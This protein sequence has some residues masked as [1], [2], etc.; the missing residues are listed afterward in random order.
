MLLGLA[1]AVAVFGIATAVQASIPDANGVIH[2]CY[3]T[4]VAHG[5]PTGAL[6]VID[7]AK[8]NGNCT[9]WEA[10]LN[11]LQSTPTG[12]TGSTGPTGPPGPTGP[13]GPTGPVN[14]IERQGLVLADGTLNFS[15]GF[16]V[17]HTAGSGNYKINFPAGTF[18]AS[19]STTDYPAIVA[20]PVAGSLLLRDIGA[21]MHL[22]GSFDVTLSTG[23]GDE[24]FEFIVVQH[25][26]PDNPGT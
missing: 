6:R 26:G 9:S 12:A 7:T 13:K 25:N 8:A 11:W 22:D 17:T 21:N 5:N 16:T 18:S 3:N 4:S 23:A 2:G 19:Q 20:M 10:R 1:V 14:V 15:S 24:E